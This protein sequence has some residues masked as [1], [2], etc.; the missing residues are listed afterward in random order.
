MNKNLFS[1][2]ILLIFAIGL[3]LPTGPVAASGITRTTF[4]GTEGTNHCYD[5]PPDPRCTPGT[6]ITLPNGQTML[7][8][9]INVIDFQT[10]DPRFTGQIVISFTFYPSTPQGMAVTGTYRFY[11]T[12]INGYWEGVLAAFLP[13]AGGIH[14]EFYATG[15]GALNGQMLKGTHTNDLVQGE[16]ISLGRP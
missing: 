14:S 11:P 2:L 12:T 10:S 13:S 6:P 8:N 1:L 15:H 5:T 16:I 4:T 9:S 7:R 3:A